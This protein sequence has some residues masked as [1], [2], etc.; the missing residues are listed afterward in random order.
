MS[1]GKNSSVALE[2]VND[3]DVSTQT[4]ELGDEEKVSDF[5]KTEYLVSNY[6]HDVGI[7]VI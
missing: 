7:K 4:K 1:D 6:A 2:R 3:H 5:E